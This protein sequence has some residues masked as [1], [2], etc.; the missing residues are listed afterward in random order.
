MT[1]SR[2]T[3]LTRT[4]V[5]V[6]AAAAASLPFSQ[7]LASPAYA[8]DSAGG[9]RQFRDA[10][11]RALARR[12]LT[13]TGEP[14]P[15]GWELELAADK[16]GSVWTRPVPGTPI[17]GVTVRIGDAETVLVHVVR[18]FHYEVDALRA[19]DVVGWRAPADVRRRLP[20]ANQ[21]SGTAVQ[22]RPGHYPSGVTGGFF[23][24]QLLVIRD[25]LAELEGVVRWGGDDRKP[26]ESLFY[27]A[28]PPGDPLLASV[29]GRLRGWREAPG[30]GAG[31]PVDVLSARRRGAAREL[32]RRQGAAA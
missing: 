1:T 23:P 28:V 24:A 15:N 25:I 8:A 7:Y 11:R 14:G 26:D 22:I 18:R 20:E 17:R 21:A 5:I 6:G 10:A 27:L 9:T 2:R 4:A 30:K 16:G 31:G 29:V 19:G 12:K 13:H 3:F 32:A